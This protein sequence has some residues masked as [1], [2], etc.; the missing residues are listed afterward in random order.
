MLGNECLFSSLLCPCLVAPVVSNSLQPCGL[1]PTRLLCPRGSPGKNTAVGSHSL[2]LQRIFS[3]QAWGGFFVIWATG[4]ALVASQVVL[5][6]KSLPSSTRDIKRCEKETEI[7]VSPGC[8][9]NVLCICVEIMP[10]SLLA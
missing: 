1:Q 4:E 3:T 5:V 8:L 6:V 2:L 10:P 9:M 7:A